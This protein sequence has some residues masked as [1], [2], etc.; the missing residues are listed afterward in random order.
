[1]QLDIDN[2]EALARRVAT[3]VDERDAASRIVDRTE[4]TINHRNEDWSEGWQSID[5]DTLHS[6]LLEYDRLVSDLDCVDGDISVLQAQIDSD[7]REDEIFEAKLESHMDPKL[8]FLA[9]RSQKK[10]K[11]R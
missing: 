7:L 1:M 4:V 6:F 8:A 5:Q 9:T 2:G 11:M 10:L 3:L